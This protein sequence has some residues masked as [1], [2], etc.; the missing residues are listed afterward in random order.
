MER[1]TRSSELL[2]V[3]SAQAVL[4]RFDDEYYGEVDCGEEGAEGEFMEI[5]VREILTRYVADAF[6]GGLLGQTRRRVADDAA[7]R[8][9]RDFFVAW[10]EYQRFFA[11]GA[12][13]LDVATRFCV[14][15]RMIRRQLGG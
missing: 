3:S 5:P 8:M 6:D 2:G 13:S 1:R 11:V 12:G 14:D 7:T 10:D 15:A 9:G 4:S